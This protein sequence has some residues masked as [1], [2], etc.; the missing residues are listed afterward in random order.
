MEESALLNNS[1][2]SS[3]KNKA[4]SRVKLK[5]CDYYMHV[6]LDQS[7]CGILSNSCP[8][9]APATNLWARVFFL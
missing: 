2:H 1:S 3:S 8:R 4:L 6:D 9:F 5:C 7:L